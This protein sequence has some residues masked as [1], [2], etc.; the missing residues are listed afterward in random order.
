MAPEQAPE[1][2]VP[3]ELGMGAGCL[4]PDVAMLWVAAL[5]GNPSATPT[6]AEP[7]LQPSTHKSCFAEAVPKHPKREH[8]NGLWRQARGEGLHTFPVIYTATVSLLW[9]A[10]RSWSQDRSPQ[11]RVWRGTVRSC[12]CMWWD[13]TPCPHSPS[14][15]PARSLSLAQPSGEGK[16]GISL[17]LAPTHCCSH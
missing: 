16:A 2:S 3:W 4:K 7:E 10:A 5:P 1:A 17:P 6:E 11:C 9:A 8:L 14:F 15:G 12:V 13:S